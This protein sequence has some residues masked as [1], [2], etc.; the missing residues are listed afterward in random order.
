[1]RDDPPPLCSA[2]PIGE[3]VF[4]W[5]GSIVGPVSFLFASL[6][7]TTQCDTFVQVRLTLLTR[8]A[9][10]SSPSP[11]LIFTLSDPRRSVLRPRSITPTST[12]TVPFV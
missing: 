1:M 6:K 2:S 5:Q 4:Q 10:S 11:S 8:A 7:V 9:F 12:P 3:D